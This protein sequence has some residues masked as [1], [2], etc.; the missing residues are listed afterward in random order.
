M[1][2]SKIGKILPLALLILPAVAQAKPKWKT[3]HSANG[4]KVA[5][6]TAR[7]TTNTDESYSVWTQ[8]DYA[9]PRIL[10][11]KKSYSR[12]VE[13]ADLKCKPIVMKRVNTALYDAAGNVVKAPEELGQSEVR[14]MSWDPPKRGSDGEKVWASVCRTISARKTK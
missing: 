4:L 1:S 2:F 10:E 8:W 6:D 9:T 14:V 13:R 11:N 12:L 7:I 5:I 3:V